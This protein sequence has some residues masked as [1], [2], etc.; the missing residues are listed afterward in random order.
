MK[1]PYS[2]HYLYYY[3]H[4]I[5]IIIYV[6]APSDLFSDHLQEHP[7]LCRSRDASLWDSS[8]LQGVFLPLS[9]WK[10][11]CAHVDGQ[12]AAGQCV[13]LELLFILIILV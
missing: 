9:G 2:N 5:I 11:M 8:A 13:C 4:I 6:G 3:N 12:D 7:C 10:P 1:H